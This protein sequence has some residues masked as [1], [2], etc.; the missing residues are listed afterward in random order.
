MINVR[1]CWNT[2]SI[3]SK[4]TQNI[5][6]EFC[7]CYLICLPQYFH[8]SLLD[9]ILH[10]PQWQFRNHNRTK[11]CYNWGRKE[12]KNS[13]GLFL[14]A[15]AFEKRG[16]LATSSQTEM[17]CRWQGKQEMI[18]IHPR[19]EIIF[20]SLLTTQK[21]RVAG[22]RGW[23]RV[24]QLLFSTVMRYWIRMLHLNSL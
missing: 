17:V 4:E 7:G 23:N 21:E 1:W 22:E 16:Q 8:C 24:T 13:W 3:N 12:G 19:P 5:N 20:S 11:A 10:V 15:T 9:S 2:T 14:A 18:T 6:N